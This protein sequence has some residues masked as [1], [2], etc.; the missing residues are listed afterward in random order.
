MRKCLVLFAVCVYS[1]LSDARIIANGTP[2]LHFNGY[3][4]QNT[5]TTSGN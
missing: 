5:G 2:V 1:F 3:G 4:N